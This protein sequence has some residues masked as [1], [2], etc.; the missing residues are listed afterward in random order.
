MAIRR[1]VKA[2]HPAL[3][4][5]AD[6]VA[7]PTAPEIQALAVDLIDSLAE[8]GGIGLAA[9]Q[10]AM[11]LRVVLYSVPA[12]RVTDHPDDGAQAPTII[13]NPVL[14]DLDDGEWSALEGCL[15]MPGLRG[16][17][18]RRRRMRLDWLDLDGQPR[19]RVVGGWHARVLQHECDHLDGRL[20]PT[21][22]TDLSTLVYL[23][24]VTLER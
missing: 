24:E 7:D 19:S 11:P 18:P 20:Y 4:R 1:V 9:P 13:V 21:R 16:L 15:S 12:A 6:A 17:V 14:T 3:A 5:I 23:D 10:I 2:G 22:M 8:A